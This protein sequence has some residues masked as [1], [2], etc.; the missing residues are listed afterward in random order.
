M[1]NGVNDS[2]VRKFKFFW[3]H[4][5]QEQESWLRAMARAGLHLVDV[6]PLCFWTFRRGAPA[7]VVYR[8]DFSSTAADGD[9]RQLMHDAGWQLA[10]TTVGWQ[11]WCIDAVDG[12]EPEIYTDSVSR[13]KKFQL[14]LAML[15]GSGLPVFMMIVNAD[16]GALPAQFTSPVLLV[17]FALLFALYLAL[18]PYTLVRLLLRIHQIR[19][20][21]P[22]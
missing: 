14:L 16:K 20:A 5:D 9:F 8:V 18:V 22:A 13:T 11:Y 6:N 15:I 10:A 7:D 17:V 2:T 21:G 19:G 4:Q 1:S 3:A 12:R